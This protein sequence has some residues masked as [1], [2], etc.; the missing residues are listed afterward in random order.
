M[1]TFPPPLVSIPH[2]TLRELSGG[3]IQASNVFAGQTLFV[4]FT[5]GNPAQLSQL[6]IENAFQYTVLNNMPFVITLA[7]EL[8]IDHG[9][10]ELI[11]QFLDGGISHATIHK[12]VQKVVGST[13]LKDVHTTDAIAR[14]PLGTIRNVIYRVRLSQK[15]ANPTAYASLFPHQ[16]GLQEY[17]LLTCFDQ[18]GQS[19][20]WVSFIDWLSSTSDRI[21]QERSSACIS[22]TASGEEIAKA[23]LV[24]YN[25]LYGTRTAFKQFIRKMLPNEI[26][27]RL[28]DSI[29]LITTTL[30]DFKIITRNEDKEDKYK[31]D[32][33]YKMRN[34]FTHSGISHTF[35]TH[36]PQELPIPLV[37]TTVHMRTYITR[38]HRESFGVK[39][40][41]HILEISVIHG[42]IRFITT[43]ADAESPA[44]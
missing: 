42:L 41:P 27:R 11:K 25:K 6:Q 24:H 30:D 35:L 20:Y 29:Q 13:P 33:L 36:H 12:A 9:L 40:W 15:L 1:P 23:F 34:D 26:R 31:E 37:D 18:L 19:T 2:D 4:S 43:L 16:S 5:D 10:I 22:P 14:S 21:I 3:E 39:D 17:L 8:P 44:N 7:S 32:F 28:L 38:R